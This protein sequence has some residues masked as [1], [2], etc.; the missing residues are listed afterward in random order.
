[1]K[2]R[3]WGQ[4]VLGTYTA[5]GITLSSA[6]GQAAEAQPKSSE[7]FSLVSLSKPNQAKCNGAVPSGPWKRTNWPSRASMP[8]MYRGSR[9]ARLPCGF[10]TLTFHTPALT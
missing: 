6:A 7:E 4:A 3:L 2:A 8:V 5:R 1:M 9:M 10:Q